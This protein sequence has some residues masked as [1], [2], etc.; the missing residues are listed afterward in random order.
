MRYDPELNPRTRNIIKPEEAFKE[1]TEKV[2]FKQ[3]SDSLEEDLEKYNKT[4]NIDNWENKRGPRPWEEGSIKER[5]IN[6]VEKAPPTVKEL[7]GE[8]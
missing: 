2:R 6:R 7:L 4:V 1:K 3:S 8:S 5:P